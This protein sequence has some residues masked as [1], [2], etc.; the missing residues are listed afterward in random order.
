M[1]WR[2][3]VLPQNKVILFPSSLF[4]LTLF[5]EWTWMF[6]APISLKSLSASYFRSFDTLNLKRYTFEKLVLSRYVRKEVLI[7][8]AEYL[9][10]WSLPAQKVIFINDP[11]NSAALPH[12][13]SITNQIASSFTSRQESLMLL[14]Y[15]SIVNIACLHCIQKLT[16]SSFHSFFKTII[17]NPLIYPYMRRYLSCICD[18]FQLQRGQ[19]AAIDGFFWDG[20]SVPNIRRIDAGQRAGLHHGIRMPEAHLHCKDKLTGQRSHFIVLMWKHLH[21]ILFKMKENE[22]TEP[23]TMKQIT[24]TLHW[25][26]F[27]IRFCMAQ[28]LFFLLL[29]FILLFHTRR[30]L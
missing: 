29:R 1:D 26:V 11:C 17:M 20:H 9:P 23:Y 7:W 18:R 22:A 25:H 4:D 10:K 15:R 6:L 12:T 2:E 24:L 13:G 16:S 30:F 27:C 19:A 3:D 21:Y 28:F 14:W 8:Q 5:N